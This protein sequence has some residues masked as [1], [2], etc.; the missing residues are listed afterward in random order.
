MRSKKLLSLILAVCLVF[1]VISP[2]A[3]VQAGNDMVTMADK[4]QNS[5]KAENQSIPGSAIIRQNC[6]T[7]RLK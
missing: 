6:K 4:Q 1:S 7:V 5:D 3:A 2:A